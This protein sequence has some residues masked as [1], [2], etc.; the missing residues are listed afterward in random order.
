MRVTVLL[1]STRRFSQRSV[2][3]TKRRPSTLENSNV[4]IGIDSLHRTNRRYLNVRGSADFSLGRRS[5]LAMVLWI[6]VDDT[7]SLQGMCT[8]FLAA[9]IVRE[10]TEDYDLIGFPRLVRLNPN[11][12]WK[13]RG[14]GAICLRFGRGTGRRNLI[15]ELESQP[16]WSFARA[17]GVDDP[18]RVQSRIANLVERRSEFREPTTNPGFCILSKQPAATLYWKA[19]RR[20]VSKEEALAAVRSPGV[21]REYKNGRGII[22]ALAAAAWRPRDRTY[23]VLAYRDE[24]RWGTPRDLESDSVKNMDRSFASTFNNYDYENDRIVIAPRSPCPILLGIRGDDPSVLPAALQTIKGE[25]PAGWIVFETNQGTDDHVIPAPTFEPQT[26]VQVE[27]QVLGLPRTIR[28]G[29]VVLEM[30]GLEAVAY[31]PSKGFRNIVRALR[32][33]DRVRVVGSIRA[34]PKTLNIEKLQ[35]LSLVEESRKLANPLCLRCQ[36][37]AKSMGTR[38]GFRCARCGQ[39]FPHSAAVRELVSRALEPGWYEPPAGSRRH[40]SQPLSR[41]LDRSRRRAAA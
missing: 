32:P 1:W 19:V 38:A 18:E 23:E 3:F 41:R 10:L 7:D 35:V 34:Q 8:T 11:V 36:K 29:H 37:R 28:G 39:R 6:G 22:G 4:L 20:I 16:V 13:T 9:E 2:G 5:E 33:G 26:T 30:N 21:L 15:G 25:S 12:P 31:E 17:E 40:L 24:S 14:N 27:T